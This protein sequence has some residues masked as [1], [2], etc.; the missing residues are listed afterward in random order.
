MKKAPS[1]AFFISRE[2]DAE[3]GQSAYTCPFPARH[4]PLFCPLERR[5]PRSAERWQYSRAMYDSGPLGT[6]TARQDSR[7]MHDSEALDAKMPPPW[8]DLRAM[9]PKSPDCTLKRI[10]GAKILPSSARKACISR[11]RCQG[12]ASFRAISE[13]RIHD[14]RILPHQPKQPYRHDEAIGRRSTSPKK[15]PGTTA[16]SPNTK[17]TPAKP[18][19]LTPEATLKSICHQ[20]DSRKGTNPRSMKQ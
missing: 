5:G 16:K 8:Q 12:G 1:G 15:G 20:G 9:Y 19:F 7:P 2:A 14:A 6:K 17:A 3:H 13:K 11:K 4:G 10:H 18:L